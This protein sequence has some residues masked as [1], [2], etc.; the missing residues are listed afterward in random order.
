MRRQSGRILLVEH[1]QAMNHRQVV[2]VSS[3]DVRHFVQERRQ[4][5]A[6]REPGRQFATRLVGGHPQRLPCG[7]DDAFGHPFRRKCAPD[8][9]L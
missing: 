4:Q 3:Q 8:A 2:R 1:L 6:L 5:G 9:P 7:R